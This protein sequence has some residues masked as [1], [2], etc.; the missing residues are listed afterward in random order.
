MRD[1]IYKINSLIKKEISSLIVSEIDFKSGV[2][3]TVSDV[4]T[5]QDLSHS[6]IKVQILPVTE[7]DY[8]MA[9][10]KHEQPVLQKILHRRLHMK[11]VPKI[12]FDPDLRGEDV[13]TLTDLL[14]Q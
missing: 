11:I 14:S 7:T 6:H 5:N 13:D 12:S 1:R 10:L 2:L 3:V 8:A 4:S 9:T